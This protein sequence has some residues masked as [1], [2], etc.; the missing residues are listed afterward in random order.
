ML[1]RRWV[2][3]AA[4][5]L[6]ATAATTA[7]AAKLTVTSKSLYGMKSSANALPAQLVYDSFTNGGTPI[8]NTRPANTGQTWKLLLGTLRLT[9]SA[10]VTGGYL[11]CTTCANGAY[12]AAIIDANLAKVT[13][14]VD[15]RSANGSGAAGLVLNVNAAGTQAFAVWYD[16]GAVT[17][18][19]Y[20]IGNVTFAPVQTVAVPPNNTDVPLSVTFNGSSYS[21]SFNSQVVMTYNLV[22]ADQT[23]FGGNTNFGVVIFDDPGTVRMDDFEVKQ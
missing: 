7:H 17:L 3:L 11:Q 12:S 8:I 4:V 19:R 10:P 18:L 22:A 16:S 13:A 6:L 5:A 9:G 15:V 23:L 20:D 1:R 21:V 14:S 2:L